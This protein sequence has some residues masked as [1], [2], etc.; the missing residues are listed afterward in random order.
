MTTRIVWRE[1]P[2]TGPDGNV[3]IQQD[4]LIEEDLREYPPVVK[5]TGLLPMTREV[6]EEFTS[7]QKCLLPT[8]AC[9]CNDLHSHGPVPGC[10][11]KPGHDECCKTNPH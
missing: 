1:R 6:A 4:A 5:Y 8:Y 11:G 2:W 7:C 3:Y 9:Q 10:C